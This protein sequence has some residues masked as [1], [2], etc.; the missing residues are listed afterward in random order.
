MVD[1]NALQKYSLFGG[2]LPEQID[3]I[4]PLMGQEG[5]SADEDIIREGEPNDRIRFVLEGRVM[6]SKAGN[7]I[8]EIGEGETFGELEILDVMP[9]A[10]TCRAIRPTRVATIS[11]K[12]IREIYRVDVKAFALIIMNLARDLAR[13]LRRMDELHYL[14]KPASYP[15][16]DGRRR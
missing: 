4:R 14:E 9:A 8:L 1:S 3:A 2:L 12:T 15:E 6:V 5:Y 11:N 10:A 13:R 7:S 16:A